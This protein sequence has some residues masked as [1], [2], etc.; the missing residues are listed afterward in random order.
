[1]LVHAV[2]LK[3][4]LFARA[5]RRECVNIIGIIV[6]IFIRRA[7]DGKLNVVVAPD[8]KAIADSHF[9][10]RGTDTGI[11]Q[12]PNKQITKTENNTKAQRG[13][14]REKTL[15][16]GINCTNRMFHCAKER[17]RFSLCNSANSSSCIAR[18]KLS[19]KTSA[20]G[21]LHE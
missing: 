12:H 10:V 15:K 18:E 2:P 9:P 4:V 3:L 13:K 8:L 19:L 20:R 17:G 16:S 11:K 1:M 14:E 21:V 5:F 6:Y 7:E